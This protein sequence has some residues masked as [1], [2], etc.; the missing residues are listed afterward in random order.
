MC[1]I[2]GVCGASLGLEF[3]RSYFDRLNHRGP[4]DSVLCYVPKH[5]TDNIIFGF[6]RLMINGLDE[7]SN[8]PLCDGDLTLICNGEIF[9]WKD[10]YQSH[11]SWKKRTSNDCEVILH[12]FKTYGPKSLCE[13][14]D[15]EYAFA[16]FD[17][18]TSKLYM[19]RDHLGIRPLYWCKDK[20]EVWFAS[21][22]RCLLGV[23]KPSKVAPFPPNTFVTFDLSRTYPTL[24][25][26]QTI[27]HFLLSKPSY[28][29][30]DRKEVISNLHILLID[31]VKKRVTN[32]DVE[33]GALL[34]GGLD[35]SL[36]TSIAVN[37]CGIDPSTF[38][39][40]AIGM[41]GSPDLENAQKVADFLGTHH[42]SVVVTE[43]QCLD[44]IPSVIAAI[45]S[46]DCTTVRASVPHWLIA[47]YVRKSTKV[48][49]LL[50]GEVADEASG[51]YAYF[52]MAPSD[53]AFGEE[54]LRLLNSIH[55]FDGLRADR[56]IANASLEARVPFSDAKLLEYFMGVHP[57]LKRFGSFSES[58]HIEK[59][60]WREAFSDV[61]PPEVRDR[62]KNGFSDG[63]S[64][65]KASFHTII[66]AHVD[67]V[68][69][70]EEFECAKD[71]ILHNP[72]RTKETYWYR[73]L[74]WCAYPRMDT[75]IP[76]EWMPREDWCGKVDDPSARELS[77]YGGD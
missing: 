28:P 30:T 77:H 69:S 22:P 24:T 67:T 1:G 41:E 29:H 54:T 2:F 57:S 32:A 48:R 62:R 17:A 20:S 71:R 64:S 19:G 25:A 65:K 44:A 73:K 12:L 31:A 63:C 6:K 40:F 18:S 76:Y 36:V 49:I 35:S 68:I 58:A 9:N 50:T 43:K 33:V 3:Y 56:C 37:F 8:E 74:F 45:G 55:R 75:L 61:L 15:G 5:G 39:T 7:G 34:S 51:S 21:E 42:H 11:P 13:H 4:D 70:D 59:A 52:E 38:Q 26:S 60:L 66:Q 16:L 47:R 53:D 14:L 27:H 46:Y 72:P 10:L 23:S